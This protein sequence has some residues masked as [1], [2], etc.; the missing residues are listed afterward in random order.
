[1]KFVAALLVCALIGSGTA[2]AQQQAQAISE[3]YEFKQ[4]IAGGWGR[5]TNEG[6]GSVSTFTIEDAQEACETSEDVTSVQFLGD[7]ERSLPKADARKGEI[8]YYITG[9]GLQRLDTFTEAVTLYP[10]IEEAPESSVFQ[11]VW[12]LT[13]SAGSH[14][15]ITFETITYESDDLEIMTDG[16]GY[17]LKC[18]QDE[19]Q[20]LIEAPELK[21][22]YDRLVGSWAHITNNRRRGLTVENLITARR[23]CSTVRALPNVRFH[24][25]ALR[26][27]PAR[28][29]R[30]G[31]IVFY[32]TSEGLQRLDTSLRQVV[33]ITTATQVERSDTRK[34][35]IIKTVS[36]QAPIEF[37]TLKRGGRSANI[38]IE[39]K[40][41][42]LECQ[43]SRAN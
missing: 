8:A 12:R 11:T 34:I 22:L 7:A 40:G 6:L 18:P 32:R 27:L 13:T 21:T 16:S 37:A 43:N 29:K 35:W 5:I 39:G 36:G 28:D 20:I 31:N 10:T 38:L 9:S 26:Q 42:Y 33:L 24:A 41:L 3:F 2:H 15:D 25:N 19:G 14:R 30:T 17:Y 1:M 23:A 4:K